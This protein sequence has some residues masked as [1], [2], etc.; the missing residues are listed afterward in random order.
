[1]GCCLFKSRQPTASEVMPGV[2]VFTF[3]FLTTIFLVI[4]VIFVLSM[5][6]G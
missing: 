2:A 5:F 1:M 4:G 3:I 6:S